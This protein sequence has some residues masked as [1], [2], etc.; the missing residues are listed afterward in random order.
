MVGF[1]NILR[2]KLILHFQ[3]DQSGWLFDLW[4]FGQRPNR[5]RKQSR[6]VVRDKYIFLLGM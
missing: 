5:A 4:F 1:G 2:K 3:N 6:P